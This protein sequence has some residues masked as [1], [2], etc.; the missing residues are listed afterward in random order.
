MVAKKKVVHKDSAVKSNGKRRT[1]SQSDTLE[2]WTDEGFFVPERKI[3]L[4]SIETDA[5]SNESAVDAAMSRKF[6]KAMTVLEYFSRKLPVTVV[7][8]S[9]GGSYYHG[10][11]IYDRMMD[12]PCAVTIIA[13]GPVMSMG[14]IILQA[15]DKRLL[16]RNAG[17]LLHYGTSD[18][19][20][21]AID[22]SRSAAE[23]ER[24]RAIFD[25]IFLRQMQKRDPAMTPARVKKMLEFDTYLDPVRAIKLGLADGLVPRTKHRRARQ[26]NDSKLQTPST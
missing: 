19:D 26:R 12:S 7:L 20:G 23:T 24:I 6:E 25:E 9:F 2:F 22:I 4:G 16:T 21:H 17:I 10:L 15:G 8:S 11:A 5:E 3:Y 18:F 13:T 14:A 1:M